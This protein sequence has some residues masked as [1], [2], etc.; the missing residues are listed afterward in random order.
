MAAFDF[1]ELVNLNPKEVQG[2]SEFIIKKGITPT[3]LS[4]LHNVFTGVLMEE[5]IVLASQ[6]G[7]TGLLKTST[8]CARMSSG[9]GVKFSEKKWSPKKIEDTFAICGDDFPA[10]LKGYANKLTNYASM[11]E[12]ENSDAVN[13][14]SMM[15]MEA[16]KRVAP[17]AIWL[18]DTSVAEAGAATDGVVSADLIPFY[19]YFDGIFAQIFAGVTA[20]DVKRVTIIEN[21]LATPALQKTLSAGR[22]SEIL[23]AIWAEAPVT[24]K[25]D[26]NAFFYVSAGLWENE[27]QR[28]QKIGENFT[29]SYSLEGF[30]QITWNGKNLVNMETIWSEIDSDF[31]ANTTDN[32]LLNPHRIVFSSKEN[33]PYATMNESDF[34][35]LSTHFDWK[36]RKLYIAYGFT[37]DAKLIDEDQIV[38]AY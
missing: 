30:R 15:I 7:K 28:L 11:Y 22:T 16:I 21:T 24:L 5:Q 14:L 27:R 8:D 23:E 34:S 10:L 2:F 3:E 37:L 20:G 36:E 13:F 4:A 19:N 9:A 35:T 32:N 38:V 18:A 31:V 33:L 17:R 12:L 25:N 29:I 6:M 1:D 26:T